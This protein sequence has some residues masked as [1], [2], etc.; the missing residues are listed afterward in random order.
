[1]KWELI[2]LTVTDANRQ[3]QVGGIAFAAFFT[4]EVINWLLTT[5]WTSDVEIPDRWK[6]LLTD[7]ESG[8]IPAL[9]QFQ[10][11]CHPPDD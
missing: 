4:T 9:V 6:V 7:E 10:Q 11:T 3:I 8:F 5:I 1:M 2:P